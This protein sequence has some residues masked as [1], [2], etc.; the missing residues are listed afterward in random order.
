MKMENFGHSGGGPQELRKARGW[1]L[2][3]SG[4]YI[5]ELSVGLTGGVL[6]GG[7]Q[8]IKSGEHT[9]LTRAG[10]AQEL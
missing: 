2:S 8:A 5:F 6:A 9:D 4:G 3:N 7:A 10:G 1:L